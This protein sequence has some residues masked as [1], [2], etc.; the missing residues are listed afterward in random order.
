MSKPKKKK[1]QN[2]TLF[3][4]DG[5]IRY[6]ED[7]S[8]LELHS[9]ITPDEWDHIVAETVKYK[10]FVDC[11]KEIACPSLDESWTKEDE[12]YRH[13]LEVSISRMRNIDALLVA[14]HN[15]PDIKQ[16]YADYMEDNL[17]TIKESMEAIREETRKMMEKE[18]KNNGKGP[19]DFMVSGF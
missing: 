19:D 7:G 15:I 14:K 13:Q 4:L 5:S 10:C 6:Y 12:W 1:E 3:V 17:P 9:K 16:L 18:I 11:L 8:M 2:P